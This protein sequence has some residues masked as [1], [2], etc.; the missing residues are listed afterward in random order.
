MSNSVKVPIWYWI[1]AVVGLLWFL[2][3]FSAFY[4][5]VFALEQTLQSLPESQAALY[6]AIPSWVNVVFGLE[7]IGGLLG[8]IGLLLR[9]HWSR[10]LLLIS[11]AGVLCQTC[12][13]YFLSNSIQVM[14][15]PA[16]VMPLVAIAITIA[17]I[18]LA[19]KAGAAGWLS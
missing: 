17:L 18:W 6:R 13:V 15:T 7:V 8:C 14:G 5:R 19:A 16:I 2:M 12:Y 4:M 1:V 9:K 3:D 11:L 10:W